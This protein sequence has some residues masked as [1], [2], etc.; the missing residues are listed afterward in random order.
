MNNEIKKRWLFLLLG[1]E[2]PA[3]EFWMTI[4][5]NRLFHNLLEMVEYMVEVLDRGR[6]LPFEPFMQFDEQGRTVMRLGGESTKVTFTQEPFFD[7]LDLYDPGYDIREIE[8]PFFSYKDG[9]WNT[10]NVKYRWFIVAPR[11]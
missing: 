11:Y 7:D 4:L 10:N 3:L 8:T 2:G 9:K 5:K 1:T 6:N